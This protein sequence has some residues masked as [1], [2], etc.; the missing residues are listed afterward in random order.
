[1]FDAAAACEFVQ[2]KVGAAECFEAPGVHI[3]RP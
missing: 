2:I 3:D 1:M